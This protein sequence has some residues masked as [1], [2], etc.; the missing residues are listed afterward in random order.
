M[1][2][3]KE[4]VKDVF[5]KGW[6]KKPQRARACPRVTEGAIFGIMNLM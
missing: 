4:K 1:K 3:G 5:G 6:E 2:L